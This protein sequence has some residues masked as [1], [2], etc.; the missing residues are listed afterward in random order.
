MHFN[1]ERIEKNDTDEEDRNYKRENTFI[2]ISAHR[3]KIS[4]PNI[5]KL[6]QDME[7]V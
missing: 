2:N 5:G 4:F 3:K 7:K 6:I 1:I